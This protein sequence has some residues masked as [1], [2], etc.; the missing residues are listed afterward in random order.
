MDTPEYRRQVEEA[1]LKKAPFRP[2]ENGRAVPGLWHKVELPDCSGVL[3]SSYCCYLKRGT[4][5]NTII[6]MIGGGLLWNERTA[7]L[8]S[9]IETAFSG[10]PC[11][12]TEEVDPDNDYW[13][14]CL[15]ENN[16]IL[17]ALED[18][19]FRDWNIGMVNYSTGDLH[20]GAHDFTVTDENGKEVAVRCEG[21]KN[22][23]ACM[24]VF[25]EQF[26]EPSR[27]LLCGESAGGFSVPGVADEVLRSYPECKDVTLCTDSALMECGDWRGIA[28]KV[29]QVPAYLSDCLHSRDIVSDW[30]ERLSKTR[31]GL[32]CLYITGR[33]D[34]AMAQY[35][36]YMDGGAFT[37]REEYLET[38]P[39]RFYEQY[40]RLSSLNLNFGFY[41][42]DFPDALS[43]GSQHMTLT[44]PTFTENTVDGV[45]PA[46][47]LF[48]GV[49]GRIK[50]IGLALL[51][52]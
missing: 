42:H 28:E 8:P 15:R 14:F 52:E 3:G 39:E 38:L 1:L 48:D 46:Q 11:L 40:K 26:P 50:T 4:S 19:P 9:T 44:H 25:K 24:A 47:W 30:Y 6:F 13:F 7:L 33:R 35:Q 22:L 16:G 37:V 51:K 31:P 17:S 49:N 21:L 41:Y 5:D 32:R 43:A 18:N 2:M 34:A 27:L 29:W 45:T 12:Y 23:R 36:S 10:K 20:L